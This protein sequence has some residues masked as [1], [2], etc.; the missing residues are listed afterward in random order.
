MVRVFT[1][2][3]LPGCMYAE[4]KDI[5]T[6]KKNKTKLAIEVSEPKI[7]IEPFNLGLV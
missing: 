4:F 3:L 7:Y 6:K 1:A 5:K 2:Y